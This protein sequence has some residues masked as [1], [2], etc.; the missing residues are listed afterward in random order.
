MRIELSIPGVPVPK[1][2]AKAF[3]VKGRAI[4]TQ[5]N[6]T[7]QRPWASA[8]TLAARD[9]M[10]G[11]PPCSDPCEVDLYFVMPRPKKHYRTGQ[12]AAELRHDAPTMHKGTPDIDKL[13]RCVLDALT[14]VVWHDDGQVFRIKACKCYDERPGAYIKVKTGDVQ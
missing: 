8:I 13:A 3:V 12:H 11:R 2:S 4:V 1:G 10:Q 9:A 5:T 6:A 7:R 14:G